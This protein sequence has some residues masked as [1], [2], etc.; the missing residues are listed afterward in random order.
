MRN[1]KP[2]S[3]STPHRSFKTKSNPLGKQTMALLDKVIGTP[4]RVPTLAT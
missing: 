2:G 3:Y 4:T 1:E